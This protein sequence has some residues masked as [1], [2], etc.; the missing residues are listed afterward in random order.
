VDFWGFVV[1]FAALFA[2]VWFVSR[3]LF[4]R[5]FIAYGTRQAKMLE[6]LA[7][8]LPLN[9]TSRL[10]LKSGEEFI[11]ELENAAL[12][13]TRTGTRVSTRSFGAATFRVAKGVYFTGGGGRIF[14]QHC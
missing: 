8:R 9:D 10:P 11:Y 7:A 3:Q 13:E 14:T 2:G 5:R 1:L 6:S 4:R 12:M